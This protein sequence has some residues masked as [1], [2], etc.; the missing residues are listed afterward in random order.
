MTHEARH[1]NIKPWTAAAAA[2]RAL[3]LVLVAL[4]TYVAASYT[5]SILP[6]GGG[7]VL[8]FILILMFAVLFAWISLGFWTAMLGFYSLLRGVDGVLS[9]SSLRPLEIDATACTAILVPVFNEDVREVF[10]R[11]RVTLESLQRAGRLDLF[12][13]YV[14]SDSNDPDR[15]VQEEAAWAELRA[16]TG[17]ERVYYRRRRNNIKRKSGNVA[18]WCRRWGAAYRYMVVFDADSLMSGE[19]L[20]KLVTVMEERPNIGILQTAPACVNRDTFIARVQQFANRLYGPMYAAGQHFW[21][22]GDAQFWGHNAILRV[23]P[24][25]QHCALAK[26][27]GRPPLG[28]DILSHDFVEAALMRR[29][30]YGVWLAHDLGGSYEEVPPTLLDELKRDRRW[31]QGNLQHLRLLRMPRVI[32]LHRL[33]FV[34]GAMAY[35]SALLWFLFLALSSMQAFLEATIEPRYFPAAP[36]LFP[37][38]PVWHK[39]LSLTLLAATAVVL[40]LPKLAAIVLTA[41]KGQSRLFGG[42]SRLS[43]S[44]LAEI[45]TSTLLAP[46]RMLF[47][48]KFVLVTLLGGQ[49]NW[50]A[51]NRTDAA[52]TW[53]DAWR[54]HA[55]GVLL[56]AFW[57]VLVYW[58]NP[59]FFWWLSPIL[60]ALVLAPTVSVLTSRTDVGRWLRRRGV[61]LTP[62]EVDTPWELRRLRALLAQP[63]ANQQN[64]FAAAVADPLVHRIHLAQLRG[65]R[66]LAASIVERREALAQRALQEGPGSLSVEEKH[67]LLLDPER[68]KRLHRTVWQLPEERRADWGV[69]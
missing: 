52:T 58:L 20:I 22:L 4:P 64:G 38:W 17:F 3:L 28:G 47:H 32:P 16:V 61:F 24:F 50:N 63:E 21:Q 43:L 26:L 25:M 15:W 19:T 41:V 55:G 33:L 13:V 1:L 7:T 30:G 2:R 31:C 56:A 48:S 57:G 40:F 65:P 46:I 14:L 29:A 62:E 42:L 23:S 36:V 59:G 9:G 67:E 44:V 34:N 35:G 54:F 49:I 45:V 27:P 51:Q 12:D 8:E 37:E 18:D 60:L 39:E 6:N 10:A 68:L 11:L 66:K 69:A 53:G 5:A